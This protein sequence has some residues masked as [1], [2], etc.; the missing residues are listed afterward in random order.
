M[1]TYYDGRMLKREMASS[2]ITRTDTLR[3]LSLFVG[4]L[5][6]AGTGP[7]LSFT[8]YATAVKNEFNFSEASRK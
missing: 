7:I 1:L 2:T 4:C 5:M 6:N 8:V 3:Y